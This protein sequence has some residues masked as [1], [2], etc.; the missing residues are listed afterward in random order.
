MDRR[1]L[2]FIWSVLAW[3]NRRTDSAREHAC[4]ERVL[5]RGELKAMLVKPEMILGQLKIS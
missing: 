1:F 3:M 2:T 5:S 4:D